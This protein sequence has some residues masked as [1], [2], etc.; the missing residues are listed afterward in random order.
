VFT[1]I[2]WDGDSG[3]YY[4]KRFKPENSEKL[5]KLFNEHPKTRLIDYN[6]QKYP[7]LRVDFG[8][9]YKKHP[10]E[11]IDVEKFISIKNDK[12]IGKRLTINEVAKL[13]WLSPV[14]EEEPIEKVP[15]ETKPTE[16]KVKQKTEK[17]E[18]KPT[19]IISAPNVSTSTEN[20]NPEQMKLDF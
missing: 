1:V 20:N 3:F 10:E 2:Y 4:I 14:M 12:A 5:I 9:R 17:P 15:A 16:E 13:T 18:I 19:E 6:I 11:I 7:R 8:G